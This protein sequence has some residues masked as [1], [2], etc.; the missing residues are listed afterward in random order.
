M[1]IKGMLVT[2]LMVVLS[3]ALFAGVLPPA[4]ELSAID[5]MIDKMMEGYNA[6]DATAFY[7][8]WAAMMAAICTPQAF[9]TL[10]VDNYMKTF[11][12]YVSRTVN[13][14][15]SVVM[16]D[17][18]NGLLVYTAKFANNEN[19]KMSVNL[20]KENDIWKIQ[21]LTIQAMP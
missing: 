1:K 6:G 10:Y 7:A 15:E 12:A 19:I 16:A 21:Q 3:G 5:A 9:Q 17:V 14:D 11:G 18:P 2:L 4:E 13:A 8:D 20:F